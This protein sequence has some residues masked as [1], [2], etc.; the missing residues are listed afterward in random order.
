MIID[1]MILIM[2]NK[3]LVIMIIRI[4]MILRI[5]MILKDS[6]ML[7]ILV[8]VINNS[9]YSDAIVRLLLSSRSAR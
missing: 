1:L 5:A 2:P 8:M 3:I 9:S 7:I 6:D 4:F